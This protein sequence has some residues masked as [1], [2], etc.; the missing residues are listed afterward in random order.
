[1][2]ERHAHYLLWTQ[3]SKAGPLSALGRRFRLIT[4]AMVIEARPD[5]MVNYYRAGGAGDV[6][7]QTSSS[8]I[9]LLREAFCDVRIELDWGGRSMI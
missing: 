3:H 6:V 7:R 1:M 8:S 9:K 2:H 4:G 5:V